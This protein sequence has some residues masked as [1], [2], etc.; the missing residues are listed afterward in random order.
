M[1]TIDLNSYNVDGFVPGE[2]ALQ[3]HGDG[4]YL[5]VKLVKG[6]F[7][8]SCRIYFPG[9]DNPI[10]IVVPTA[11]VFTQADLHIPIYNALNWML[12]ALSVKISYGTNVVGTYHLQRFKDETGIDFENALIMEELTRLREE[13][14]LAE[15]IAHRLPEAGT[16]ISLPGLVIKYNDMRFLVNERWGVIGDLGAIGSHRGGRTIGT[17]FRPN[18]VL[19]LKSLAYDVDLSAI[20]PYDLIGLIDNY[21]EMARSIENDVLGDRRG[22]RERSRERERGSRSLSDDRDDHERPGRGSRGR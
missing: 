14:L 5:N 22:R 7:V 21:A 17:F 2:L 18:V 11:G 20:A 1:I 4:G 6:M 3:M 19:T 13:L 16:A 10:A 15:P 9:E 8:G 12:S